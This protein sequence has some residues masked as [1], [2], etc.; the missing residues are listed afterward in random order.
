MPRVAGLR[1]CGLRQRLDLRA[2]DRGATAPM[3]RGLVHVDRLAVELDRPL[4]GG[5]R[6]R[7]RAE[8]IGIADQE[9]IGAERLPEQRG[10]EP[11]GVDE[12]RLVAAGIGDD[13]PLQPLGRQR[14]I[15]IAGEFAGQ[16]LGGVDDHLGRAVLDRRKHLARAGDHDVAAEH[17]IGAPG[18]DADRV[19]VFGLLGEADVAEHR[20]ALL[21]EPGHVEH[22]DAAA[23]EMRGH[24]EDAADGDDAGA[25]D[26]G[27][28][29]VVGLLDRR[30]FRIGQRRQIVIGGDAPALFQLGAVHRDEGRAETLDAGKIL[31]AARLVDGALA[32]PF[33]LERLHRHAVRLDAAIAAALADE[34]VDDDALVGIGIGVRACGGGAFPPRRSGRRSAP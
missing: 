12:M 7:D 4:D 19:D 18:R 8:L 15:G 5:G 22:A 25:A 30:Q 34:L 1:G 17:Q 32:A 13:G 14:E 31:V 27:D 2:V 10:R 23:F 6:Q 11:R 33:G 26:A 28:D 20:A 9:H 16:K 24:A 3:E 29:D 21:R